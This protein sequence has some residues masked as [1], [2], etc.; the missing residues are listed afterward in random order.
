MSGGLYVHFPNWKKALANVLGQNHTTSS[1]NI[2]YTL[3]INID[4]LPL[5][6]HSPDYK[7]FPILCSVYKAKSRPITIGIY[8]TEKCEHRELPPPEIYLKQFL[9]DVV[10][11]ETHPIS[12]ENKTFHMVNKGTYICD[13]PIRSFLKKIK[14][15]SGYSSCERCTIVGEYNSIAGHVCLVKGKS[16]PSL[17]TNGDFESLQDLNH[18]HVTPLLYGFG[19]DLIHDFVLDYMHLACLG[20]MKRLL[21]WWKGVRR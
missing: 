14:S 13:A 16:N 9:E 21:M 6:K 5:F 4:G 7:I 2:P 11:L 8:S 1:G 15:H 19:V 10:F 18:H 17:R 12:S 3:L 20:V